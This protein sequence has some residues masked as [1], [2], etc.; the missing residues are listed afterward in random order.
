VTGLL[1]A[2]AGALGACCRVGVD[3]VVETRRGDPLGRGFP[4]GILAVNV[5]GS[6]LLGLVVGWAMY[7]GLSGRWR[8]VAGTGFC[9]GYTTFSTFAFDTVRLAEE[10][11]RPRAA[12][13]VGAS[14]ALSVAAA[15]VGLAAAAALS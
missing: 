5:T 1:V 14:I 6:L 3:E 15:A 4:F 2:L 11:D 7:H 8:A 13:Y 9:G 12:V 10:G